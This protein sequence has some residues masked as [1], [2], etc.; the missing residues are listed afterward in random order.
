[1]SMKEEQRDDKKEEVAA[2]LLELRRSKHAKP[3]PNPRRCSVCHEVG[4]YKP[5]CP[6]VLLSSSKSAPLIMMFAQGVSEK[7]KKI[8]RQ[9]NPTTIYIDPPV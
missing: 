2:I 7:T 6:R 3:E 9:L 4:H 5:R 1:M 8:S